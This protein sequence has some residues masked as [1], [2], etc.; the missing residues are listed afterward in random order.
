LRREKKHYWHEY[1]GNN[2]RLSNILAA[3][4]L[5]QLEQ[6]EAI[7]AAKARVLARYRATLAAQTRVRFQP[8]PE[9]S[10]PVIWA[11]AVQL[12]L[13]GRQETR[14]NV[15]E[16]L[17]ERGIECRP[18]FYTPEQLDLYRTGVTAHP[19]AEEVAA[20]TLVLP[21]SPRLA[22]EQIDRICAN[23][24]QILSQ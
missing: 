10:E 11:V 2:F 18:G 22:D 21:S 6:R 20:S 5:A 3:I 24:D 14:D 8:V 13:A 16:R 23:L 12:D 17:S 19:V 1:F 9:H 15:I 7:V 4:G